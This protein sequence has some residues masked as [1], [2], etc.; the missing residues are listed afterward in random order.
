LSTGASVDANSTRLDPLYRDREAGD[1]RLQTLSTGYFFDSPALEGGD[2]GFDMGAFEFYYGP[3]TETPVTVDFSTAG[4]RNPDRIERRYFS[5]K[6]AE[7]EREDGSSFSG[8]N[9]NKLEWK[10]IWEERNDMPDAQVDDLKSLFDYDNPDFEI[11]FDGGS[12]WTEVTLMH[13]DD[14]EYTEISDAYVDDSHPTPVRL[15]VFREK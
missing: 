4:Y 10:L 6:L 2:D 5:V 8:K 3:A 14:I 1:L 12:T 7:G 9:L 13:G 11:S 15:L